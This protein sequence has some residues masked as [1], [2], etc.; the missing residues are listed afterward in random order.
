MLGLVYIA[1]SI[2]SGRVILDLFLPEYRRLGEKT[3]LGR[4]LEL[5]VFFVYFPFWYFTG[6]LLLGWS[7]YLCALI[8]RSVTERPLGP[9]NAVVMPLFALADLLILWRTRRKEKTEHREWSRERMLSFLLH[10]L[11]VIL[12]VMFLIRMEYRSFAIR[13]GKI[14]VGYSVFSDFA[15]HLGMIRSFS[16]GNNFPT[17]YSH[18]AGQDIRYHFL[19]Q[20][21]AGNLEFLGL[22]LDHAFN[23]PSIL[24]MLGA[25][26]LLFVFATKLFGRR[27]CGALSVCYMTFRSSPSLFRYLAE[28]PKGSMS[29]KELLDRESFFSYTP[30]EDWGLWNFKVYLNQRHLA[31]GIGVVLMA[32]LLFAPLVYAMFE[33]LKKQ[34][35]PFRAF[36]LEKDAILP[37]ELRRG[38]FCGLLLGLSA[39]WNGAMVIG[40]LAVLFVMALCSEHRLEYLITAVLAVLLSSAQSM[41]FVR[42]SAV[43]PSYQYG[44]IADN[45]DLWGCI[46]YLL[47]LS[48][49][50]LILTTAY[51][52]MERGV[53]R[54]MLLAFSAPLV[55]A[56]TLSLTPDI[57]VNHKYVMLSFIL[58][59][60]IAAGMTAALLESRRISRI[61]GGMLLLFVLTATGV[62]EC[63]V[64]YNID[65]EALVFDED[66]PLTQWI[67]ENS[68]SDDIF[69]TDR[70]ALNEAVMGGAMLY[71]GWPYYAWSA[72]YDTT[73][74]EEIVREL[75]GADDP[76]VLR[77][78]ATE[79]GIHY[80][81]VDDG[82]RWSEDYLLRE[83]VIAAAFPLVWQKDGYS[84]Y[85]VGGT[86][87]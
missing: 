54:Y 28:L 82:L 53:L 71:Y 73:G 52:I 70:Y 2:L 68:D 47:A 39:F 57:T 14:R 69:L 59:G 4:D 20:F 56:F 41:L 12:Y 34:E 24:S 77:Q 55:M 16:Y 27:L 61:V 62:Y 85:E 1:L 10:L 78:K 87:E 35:H 25:A 38:I 67:R 42:G 33:K 17:Q 21:Q 23:L 44:F 40:G 9:A 60:I 29:L 74:R 46:A 36:L 22:P 63:R 86:K 49:L 45:P 19:F 13:Q 83:D 11:P 48:G 30:K 18:Y 84:I 76:E 58:M 65:R 31:F 5:P 8:L 75:F 64:T 37:G 66:D 26:M 80:I 43:S 15:T 81:L 72:G 7:T 3:Y 32:L 50:L 51:A 6:S 79:E